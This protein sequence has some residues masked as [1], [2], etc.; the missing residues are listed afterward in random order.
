MR[1]PCRPLPADGRFLQAIAPTPLVP[2]RL[3][4]EGPTIWCKLEFLNPSGSTKDRIARY[5]LE[6]AW[7]L[8][9]LQP[10]GEVVEASSGST[11]IALALASA[12]MGVRF[13]AVMPEGVT[14]ERV[15]TIRA[16]GGDVVLVPRAEGVRGAIAKAEEIARERKAFAPRQ[17]ENPDNAEAHR[18]WTGQEILSQIPGGLVH[19]VVSGVGTGG[20]VVG[21]YQAFAEAGCPVTAFIARPIAGLGCDIEC[22]SFSPRVPGVVDGMSKLYRDSDMPGRVELDVSDEEAMCTARALIRRGFPVGPSSGL[23]YV[24]AVEASKRLGSGAQVVTVFPD[25]MERYFSTELILGRPAPV[26]VA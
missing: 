6:K 2:V 18:V 17:F 10:G 11:S 14:D 23:N 3:D 19:G 26:R 13:T 22:C 1:P 24:A 12:Q 16:Y 15:L 7:R 5:M 4:P 9:E 21:L 20:T 8:G 25:R